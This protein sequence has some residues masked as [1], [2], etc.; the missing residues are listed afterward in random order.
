MRVIYRDHEITVTRE[1]CLGGWDM[2][3]W[4]VFRKSDGFCCEDSFVDC[5]ETV[6]EFVRQI[7]TRVDNE[8]AEEDPWGER[9][10]AVG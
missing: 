5:G 1:L 2:L 8:L 7:K 10:R 6:R 3:Y 9:A 4:S